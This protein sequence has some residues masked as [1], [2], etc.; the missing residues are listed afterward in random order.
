MLSNLEIARKI[1]LS[2]NQGCHIH[3]TKETELELYGNYKAK[4]DLSILKG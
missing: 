3:S 4:I 2:Y 1:A